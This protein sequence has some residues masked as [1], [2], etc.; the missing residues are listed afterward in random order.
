MRTCALCNGKGKYDGIVRADWPGAKIFVGREGAHTYYIT[1][2]CQNCEG[3]G[4]SEEA[5]RWEGEPDYGDSDREGEDT[6]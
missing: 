1:F 6:G 3:S 5:S 2:H 4:E